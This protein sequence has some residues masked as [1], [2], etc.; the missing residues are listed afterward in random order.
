M[1]IAIRL[2][3]SRITAYILWLKD[4]VFCHLTFLY[5]MLEYKQ[6]YSITSRGCHSEM[7]EMCES[8]VGCDF[9]TFDMC[10]VSN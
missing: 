1:L 2:S 6:R 7:C 5:R 4:W 10:A 9:H 8:G 3:N